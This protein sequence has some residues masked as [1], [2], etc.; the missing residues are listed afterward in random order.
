MTWEGGVDATAGHETLL[1]STGAMRRGSWRARDLLHTESARALARWLEHVTSMS[2]MLTLA[3]K[4]MQDRLS[5]E[6]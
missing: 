6:M 3:R 4:R 2:N 1:A 5:S